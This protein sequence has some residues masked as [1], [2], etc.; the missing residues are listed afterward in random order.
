M[1]HFG[2]TAI[3]WDHGRTEVD[4]CMVHSVDRLGQ[5][6][7]LADGEPMPFADVAS[8]IV[9][10]NEVWV[11]ERSEAG[12]YDK[13]CSVGVRAGQHEHL[14]TTPSNWLFNLPAF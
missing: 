2:V 8:L 11:M 1:S 4:V 6:F 5:E 13:G 12:H 14:Y 10:G 3:R 9:N 7:V